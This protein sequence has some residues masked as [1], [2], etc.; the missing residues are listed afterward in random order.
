MPKSVSA[1][2]VSASHAPH[3]QRGDTRA[4][5]GASRVRVQPPFGPASTHAPFAC[6]MIHAPYAQPPFAPGTSISTPLLPAAMPRPAS[7]L[8]RDED[9]KKDRAAAT[10]FSHRLLDHPSS[11]TNAHLSAMPLPLYAFPCRM[12]NGESQPSE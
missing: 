12:P 3:L 2:L 10:Q 8:K 9:R 5:P 7:L 6:D 4:P 11:R 1:R